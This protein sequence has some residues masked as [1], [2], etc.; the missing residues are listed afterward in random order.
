MADDVLREIQKKYT[1]NTETAKD[2]DYRRRTIGF[3]I[4]HILM[5]LF[6]YLVYIQF[7]Q[8]FLDDERG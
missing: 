5:I 2:F 6:Y 7:M 8:N 4:S 1:P 3:L